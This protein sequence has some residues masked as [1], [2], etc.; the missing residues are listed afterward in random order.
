MNDRAKRFALAALCV[1]LIVVLFWQRTRMERLRM[2]RA[3]LR[4]KLAAVQVDGP[5]E[6]SKPNGPTSPDPELL[7]LRAEVAELR[8]QKSEVARSNSL[9]RVAQ[10]TGVN[11]SSELPFEIRRRNNTQVLK[12]LVLALLFA[13]DERDR[14]KAGAK[15]EIVDANGGPSPEL[16][17]RIEKVLERDE[18]R[19]DI[20]LDTAWADLEFLI[21][22]GAD[23]GKVHPNTIVARTVAMKT[24]EGKWMRVYAIADGSAHL[25]VHQTPDELWQALPQ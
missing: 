21:T 13:I 23:L 14:S 19:V 12:S 11:E 1:A 7:R 4:T 15:L 16:R 8:R 3:E 5:R 22:D 6:T 18:D 20:N 17:R 10:S 2:E 25:G 9:P 24:P